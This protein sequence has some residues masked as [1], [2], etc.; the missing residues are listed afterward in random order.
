MDIKIVVVD[1]SKVA[2]AQVAGILKGA[3]YLVVEAVDGRDGIQR[4]SENKDAA[5]I[6]CDV[7]MPIMSGLEMLQR[8]KTGESKSIP[9]VMLTT[10]AQPELIQQAKAHGALGWIVKP[11]KSDLL[12]A[13]VKK[14]T[15]NGPI[16]RQP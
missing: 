16:S 1:D 10:E 9:I 11:V 12:L 8:V 6:V 3:G 5:M 4:V 13:A 14:I 2:R 15:G 7:N